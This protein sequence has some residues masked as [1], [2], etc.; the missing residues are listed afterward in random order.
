MS[1]N[2]LLPLVTV[3]ARRAQIV[4]AVCALHDGGF[5]PSA[6]YRIAHV[7]PVGVLREILESSDGHRAFLSAQ[8]TDQRL[9]RPLIFSLRGEALEAERVTARQHD[10]VPNRWGIRRLHLF[11]FLFPQPS[12]FL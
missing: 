9:T 2:E 11:A 12:P 5:L 10:R 4:I 6:V 7:A 8:R 1:R 3:F